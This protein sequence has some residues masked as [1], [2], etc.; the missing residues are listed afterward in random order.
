MAKK[1]CIICGAWYIP[2]PRTFKTQKTCSNPAC[3]KARKR[4]ADQSWRRNNPDWPTGR[5][6]KIRAWS[7]DYPAYWRQYRA[8]HPEYRAR[9]RERKRKYRV[10][11]AAKQDAIRQNPVGYLSE[12][13]RFGAKTA[14]KQDAIGEKLDGVLDYLT[15]CAR[16]AKP[17]DIGPGPAG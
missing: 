2:H 15:V 1:R 10:L 17:N 9:E 8:G 4:K 14:A 3:R 11:S 5:Q 16:V 13:R 12:V 6:G 7:A